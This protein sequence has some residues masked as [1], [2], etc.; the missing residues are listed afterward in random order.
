LRKLFLV[1]CLLS[2]TAGTASADTPPVLANAQTNPSTWPVS[3]LDWRTSPVDL[4]FLNATEKPAGKRGFLKTAKDKLIFE[5]GTPVTFWGTNLTSY[6]L[7]GTPRDSVRQQARRLSQ[8]GFNLVRIHH[9]DSFWVDPNVF[10]NAQSP[11]TRK[12]SPTM[13]EKLDWWIKCLKD[14]GIYI[15][16]DLHVQRHLKPADRI[17]AFDEI[18]R[19]V[20]GGSQADLKGYNYV[21]PS[22]R[23]AM[24]LFNER[25]LNHANIHTKVK[26]K[27]E[28]AIVAML[29]TNENDL[30]H[31]YGNKLLPDKKVPKHTALYMSRANAFADAWGLPK[32]RTWRAWEHGPSKL[33]L[34]DLEWQFNVDMMGHLRTQG[35]KV[36]IATTSTW[37]NPLSSLP[38]LTAGNV[39]DAHAYGGRGELGKNPVFEPNLVHWIA[40]AQVADKPLSVTEWNVQPFPVDDRQTI[41]LYIAASA[42][43]QGWGALMQYAYAQVPLD[44]P[45][46]PS[47]WAA[48]NDPA[49]LAILP[50]AALL[51]RRGD[52]REARTTYAFTLGREQFFGQ[53]ISPANSVALRTAAETGRLV[54]VPP[55]A[56][57]LPWLERTHVPFGARLL[58][59]PTQS[60]IGRHTEEAASDTGELKRNWKNGSYVIN[61]PRSQAA[62]G[63][64]GN[65]TIKLADVEITATT[66][67]A[68]ISVQSLENRP[69]AESRRILISVAARSAPRIA[70]QLP[71]HSE[72]V[73][74]RLTIRAPRGLK[75]HL[76]NDPQP[77]RSSIPVPYD[78]GRYQIDLALGPGSG[79]LV[80]K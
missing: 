6:A 68:T 70:R 61:T 51:Y 3:T 59:D 76:Q 75:L 37:G 60:L 79:W 16:L 5:D 52:V 23:L 74:G 14:E 40:A 73:L 48:F 39:I 77:G 10:G 44:T 57:E 64:I 45:G 67:N 24:K 15:W 18:S 55:Q 20:K 9:H 47:N 4:S 62:M 27:D 30:T 11:D 42:R 25:Y 38:A 36:P 80:L 32:D 53:A 13:L 66:R 43:L 26:Y 41:P 22:I 35:V 8:L 1:A 31:H 54:I 33:F 78:S 71:F 56:R 21:N 49:L 34:N 28:P 7:F 65:M 2:G 63:S 29:I 50:S 19:I 69:I 46:A 17:D 72:P 58:S 12:L